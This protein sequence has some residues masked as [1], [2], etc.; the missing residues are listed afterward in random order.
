MSEERT[1]QATPRRREEARKRGEAPR[2]VELAGAGA[3]IGAIVGLRLGWGGMVADAISTLIQSMRECPRW[4]PTLAAAVAVYQST[5]VQAARMVAPPALGACVAALVVS[6]AQ[7]SFVISAHPLGLKWARLSLGQGLVRMVSRQSVFAM[8]RSVLRLV[9]VGLVA[10]LFLRGR[11]AALVMLAAAPIPSA[12]AAL[13]SLIFGLLVRIAGVLLL[14]AAADYLYQRHEHERRL[15]MTRHEQRE[16]HKQTEGDPLVRSRIR[17]R[18]RAMARQR[19][20][21]AVKRA[22]V[23]ITNPVE[24][25]VALRYDAEKTPAPIVVAKGRLLMAERIRDEATRH[26]VPVTPSPD[27]ARALYRS[28]PI[29]RQIP[30]ELYQAVAEILAFVYRLTAQAGRLRSQE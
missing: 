28:V 19:M 20:I 26:S 15:R 18:Q 4:Q 9:L 29:G 25:A 21:D 6:L 10:F 23:V 3:M 17:E 2:S 8:L 12:A 1:E 22:T 30:P 11:A 7:S 5:L 14:C 24:I 13:G 16:E 27:L